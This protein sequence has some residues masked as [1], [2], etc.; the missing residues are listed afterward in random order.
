MEGHL[1]RDTDVAH[2]SRI[3]QHGSSICLDWTVTFTCGMYMSVDRG[4][5]DTQ[6]DRLCICLLCTPTLTQLCAHTTAAPRSWHRLAMHVWPLC[7]C[8][9]RLSL[10]DYCASTAC[11]VR[12]PCAVRPV[13]VDNMQSPMVIDALMICAYKCV[14]GG[15]RVRAHTRCSNWIRLAD[16]RYAHTSLRL[17]LHPC[18]CF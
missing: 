9:R 11:P 12:Q 10:S 15:E 7:T 2:C 4:A 13:Y 14:C 6:L 3:A 17:Q 16:K 5:T 1:Q 8:I 18:Q